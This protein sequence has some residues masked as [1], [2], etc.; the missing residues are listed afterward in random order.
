[1]CSHRRR[2]STTRKSSGDKVRLSTFVG[3]ERWVAGLSRAVE[4]NRD[5]WHSRF[6]GDSD[7]DRPVDEPSQ[8]LGVRGWPIWSPAVGRRRMG[9]STR[10]MGARES[11]GE[12]IQEPTVERQGIGRSGPQWWGGRRWGGRRETEGGR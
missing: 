1:M 11:V 5:M 2:S 10:E 6:H 7:E 3:V 12:P 8:R 4:I 9:L